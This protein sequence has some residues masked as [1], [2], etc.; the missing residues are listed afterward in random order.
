[1]QLSAMVVSISFLN[2]RLRFNF[3]TLAIKIECTVCVQRSSEKYKFGGKKIDRKI[4][5]L[6][7]KYKKMRKDPKVPLE[8]IRVAHS[9]ILQRCNSQ[10]YS[11]MNFLRRNM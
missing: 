8:Q 7:Q 3:L 11:Q 2:V 4:P 10:K 1:M 9:F 5:E 6:S